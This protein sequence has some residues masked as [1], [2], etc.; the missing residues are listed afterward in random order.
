MKKTTLFLILLINFAFFLNFSKLPTNICYAENDDETLDENIEKIVE[1][2]DFSSLDEYLTSCDFNYNKLTAKEFI[3]EII[4]GNISLDFESVINFIFSIITSNIKSY[5][6]VLLVILTIILLCFFFDKIKPDGKQNGTG[7]IIY[8]VCFSIVVA[9]IIRL[10]GGVINDSYKAMQ[11]MQKQMSIVFPIM[12]T[13]ILSLGATGTAAALS[14]LTLLLSNIVS[15]IFLYCLVP[16]F[17]VVF[18][19]SILNNISNKTKFTKLIDFF[20]TLFKYILG[21]TLGVYFFFFSVQGVTAGMSD[22]VSLKAARYAIKNYVPVLGG[23]VSEGIDIVKIGGY[24][25]KNSVGII[26]CILIFGSTLAPII[27][28][29]IFSLALKVL[30]GILEPLGETKSVEILSGVGKSFKLL[31]TC[32]LVIL[33]MYFVMII[34]IISSVSGVL[35][36]E[37][38]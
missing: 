5:L 21:I 27:G 35:V 29:A 17:T 37:I 16:I 18:V 32:L 33:C 8:F 1:N 19:L 36:W 20:N 38:F 28:I 10:S 22:G 3:T 13:L 2:I 30:A 11:N 6:S 9:L 31:L 12:L 24:L 15:S 14:P 23:Y 25:V 34:F 7:N 4:K 26:A